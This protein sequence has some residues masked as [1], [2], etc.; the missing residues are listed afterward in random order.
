[1]QS[2]NPDDRISAVEAA[3]EHFNIKGVAGFTLEYDPDIEEY[4][5]TWP[6][7]RVVLGQKPFKSWSSLGAT[8]G[9]EIEVHVRQFVE[10]GNIKSNREFYRREIEAHKYNLKQENIDRFRNTAP[11]I[12]NH[13]R[14]LNMY[15][16]KY[17]R[18]Q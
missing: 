5:Q 2:T 17:E 1:M 8:L 3:I 9:H 10:F 11:E 13:Q 18:Y 14:T 12:F 4:A 16:K 7:L 6:T 15:A